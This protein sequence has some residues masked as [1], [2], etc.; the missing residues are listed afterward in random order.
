MAKFV[1][2]K[3][4]GNLKM[5]KFENLK[6][7]SHTITKKMGKYGSLRSNNFLRHY[8][9]PLNIPVSIFSYFPHFHTFTFAFSNFQIIKL[10]FRPTHNVPCIFNIDCIYRQHQRMEGINH[11]S[12]FLCFL[13]ADTFFN[14]AG[15][16][17]MGY[18]SWM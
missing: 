12:Q 3:M 6:I 7:K 14:G 2:R 5:W 4:G 15:M 16:G 17:T 18:A 13:C 9:R 10:L 8:Y 1:F 11:D